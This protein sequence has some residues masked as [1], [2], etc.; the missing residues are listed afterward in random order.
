MGEGSGIVVLEELE[1]ALKRGARIYA[2]I[3]G[4]GATGDAYH[5]TAP[6]PDGEGAQ[7][8]MKRALKDAGR[9][10]KDIQYI[11]AHGTSTPANDFNETRAI[12]AVFGDYAKELNVRS[13]K[14]AAGHKL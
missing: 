1:H 9:E 10:P 2:E 7:R 14:S 12:K 11:N 5:L 3:A 13:T 8:A 6:A 4:Y